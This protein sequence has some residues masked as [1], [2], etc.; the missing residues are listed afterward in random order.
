MQILKYE[1]NIKIIINKDEPL[2]KNL[3]GQIDLRYSNPLNM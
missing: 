3:K 1:K 2:L